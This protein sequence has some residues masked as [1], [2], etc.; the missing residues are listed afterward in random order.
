MDNSPTLYL[1]L[2]YPGSGKT[3]TARVIHELT[4]AVHLWA[5]HIRRERFVSPTYSH[6]ENLALY[7]HLNELTA[8]LLAAG[9]DV[10]FDTNFNFYKDRQNLRD[11]A[12]QHGAKTKLIWVST[13]KDLAR[14]RA[15]D[16]AHKHNTRVLGHM[17]KEVFDRLT[18]NLEEP[19]PD[20][21]PVKV[22]G[23]RVTPD[24]IKSLIT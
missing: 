4:G 21:R 19:R 18:S 5:D 10:I 13:E 23:T 15:V 3:T 17:P 7:K 20:E 1:M 16:E 9:N 6:E 12:K 2:G 11:I 8:E 22:D 24:Y 14:Q